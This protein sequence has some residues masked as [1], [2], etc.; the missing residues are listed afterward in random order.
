MTSHVEL[1]LDPTWLRH[2]SLPELLRESSARA[3]SHVASPHR[4]QG[5]DLIAG[6]VARPR[7]DWYTEIVSMYLLAKDAALWSCLP[8]VSTLR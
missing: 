8:C 4:E 1:L 2:S 5:P 6:V 3:G 7:R